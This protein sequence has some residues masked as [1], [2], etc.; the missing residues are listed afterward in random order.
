MKF[1]REPAEQTKVHFNMDHLLWFNCKLANDVEPLNKIYS[2]IFYKA[3]L[4]DQ[5]KLVNNWQTEFD[6]DLVLD[7]WDY[8][9]FIF[10]V[11]FHGDNHFIP[12][13]ISIIQAKIFAETRA[14]S[15]I[16]DR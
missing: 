2:S 8:T 15:G 7:C 4:Q 11:V 10:E 1:V 12:T 3:N 13:E 14:S 9:H 5:T 16:N 6:N